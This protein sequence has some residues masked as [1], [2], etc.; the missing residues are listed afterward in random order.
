MEH[1]PAAA[2][3]DEIHQKQDGG[4]CTWHFQNGGQRCVYAGCMLCV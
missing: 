4:C 2:A 3:T 1:K